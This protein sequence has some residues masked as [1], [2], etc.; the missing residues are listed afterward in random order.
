VFRNDAR[1]RNAN[2]G[3]MPALRSGGSVGRVFTID[4]RVAWGSASAV[5]MNL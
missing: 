3:S 1:G 2:G 5:A 4:A